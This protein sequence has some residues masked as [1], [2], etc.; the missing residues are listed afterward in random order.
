[1]V[2]VVTRRFLPVDHAR[3]VEINVVSPVDIRTRLEPPAPVWAGTNILGM[4][5]SVVAV[6]P[7]SDPVEVGAVVGQQLVDDLRSGAIH[8]SF[9]HMAD[10]VDKPRP[11]V[12]RTITT[13]LGVIE[14]IPTPQGLSIT[15]ARNALRFDWAPVIAMM[16]ATGQSD[17]P[18]LRTSVHMIHTYRGRLSVDFSTYLS[19]ERAE[20]YAAEFEASLLEMAA[21]D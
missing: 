8:Q 17:H 12:P 2:A 13:N 10:S 21:R 5:N 7:R 19:K 20:R 6:S 3:A 14:A 16:K 11:L 4:T 1:M 9:L 18:L 15:Q